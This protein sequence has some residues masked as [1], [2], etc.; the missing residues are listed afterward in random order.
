VR[1]LCGTGNDDFDGGTEVNDDFG[2][3]GNNTFVSN[4]VPSVQVVQ[5][6]NSAAG[7]PR[8]P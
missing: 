5:D 8:F 6:W 7:K 2:G 1:A 4:D 3:R